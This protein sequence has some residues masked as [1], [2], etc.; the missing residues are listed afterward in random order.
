M[1]FKIELPKNVKFIIDKFK[2]NGF[3]SYAVGGCV[4][5]SLINRKVNDWDITTNAKPED[6]INIFEK[7]V[8]TGIKHGTVTVILDKENF[9]VTTYRIDG[10]YKDGRHP[11]EVQFVSELKEDLSRRD[12]TI[13]AMAYNEEN[14]L[15]DYF[16]GLEDLDNKI[17]RAVGNADKRFEEDALRMLRAIRF[18][19]QLGFEI[20][21]STKN[22]G[23]M[24]KNVINNICSITKIQ[25]EEFFKELW[26]KY[27]KAKVN[28]G[29]AVGAVAGQSIGEPATQMTLKTFHFAGVASMN[30]TS[31]IPR[32]KEIIN[33]TQKISTPVIYAKLIQEDDVTAARIVKGR[34][35]KI[36]LERVCEYIK[37]IISPEGCYIKVKLDEKYINSSHLEI[38]IQ[39]VR[40]ALLLN[41]KKLNLKLRENHIIIKNNKKLI[42]YPPETDRNYLYFSLEVMMKN[43]PEI[44]ISGISTVNRVVINKKDK[45]EKKYMLAIEGTG[46]LDVMKTDGIDYKHCTSNNIGENR[47]G[48]KINNI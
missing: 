48:K 43:L 44:V 26:T 37:E 17:I 24:K 5:D 30:I 27:K 16:K 34:I 21:E 23:S 47:S 33:Y 13:N 19:A 1:E 8:P 18:A 4:R 38:T 22:F 31:G 29:E 41:K 20:E 12:F 10:E 32:I 3:E 42:I 45:D 7:T 14:G 2:E 25:L 15:I 39:K 36:K 28:P 46:L 6:T 35:E 11:E 9:E 40:E